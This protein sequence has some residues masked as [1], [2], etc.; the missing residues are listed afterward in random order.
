MGYQSRLVS[1][2]FQE[3][4]GSFGKEEAVGDCGDFFGLFPNRLKRFQLPLKG[5]SLLL[6]VKGHLQ[7]ETG[8]PG[9]FMDQ[10]QVFLL[11]GP[12]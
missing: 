8:G 1:V 10:T 11:H 5:S 9:Q 12:P 2:F 4:I 3:F 6:F 7:C